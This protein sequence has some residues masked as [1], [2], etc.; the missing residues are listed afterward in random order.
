[1][2]QDEEWK[3]GNLLNLKYEG[4]IKNDCTKQVRCGCTQR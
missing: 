3:E 4:E 1:M 2:K